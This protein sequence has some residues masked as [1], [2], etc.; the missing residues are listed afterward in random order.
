[1]PFAT[2]DSGTY[3]VAPR[4]QPNTT[5]LSAVVAVLAIVCMSIHA[6]PA[7]AIVCAPGSLQD[8]VDLSAGCTIGPVTFSDFVVL[9]PPAGATPIS[10][11]TI[12]VTPL[13]DPSNPGF[14]F[15]V[16]VVA[17]AGE[18]FDVFFGFQVTDS[19]IGASLSMDGAA[20]AG[21]GAVTV[22][23]DLC[24]G[25]VFTGLACSGDPATM[26]VFAIEGDTQATENSSLPSASLLGVLADIGVDGGLIGTGQLG[27]TTLRFETGVTTTVPEPPSLVVVLAAGIALWFGRRRLLARCYARRRRGRVLS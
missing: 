20:A 9:S 26:I 25:G 16:N 12:S 21:D 18:F 6:A 23:E 3:T 1:M 15:G 5:M 17:G 13:G 10:P 11:T 14:V 22:V 27:T 2:R 7:Y 19:L 8:Y 24:A 4:L